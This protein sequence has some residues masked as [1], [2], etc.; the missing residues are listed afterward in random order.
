MQSGTAPRIGKFIRT[1]REKCCRTSEGNFFPRLADQDFILY[2]L[3]SCQDFEKAAGG[4]AAVKILRLGA[5][6]RSV[7]T[8]SGQPSD[9]HRLCVRARACVFLFF[10]EDKPCLPASL[11]EK[12]RKKR[13]RL[14]V[15]L[16]VL[17]GLTPPLLYL[18]VV[19]L[20]GKRETSLS[21]MLAAMLSVLR[22]I[23]GR[24]CKATT[25]E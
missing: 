25:G 16:I 14:G 2:R 4:T 23:S 13:N 10:I 18:F 8:L 17:A 3:D 15:R 1:G 5:E 9:P 19:R 11:E 7:G 12:K 20:E 22:P 24:G 21:L 6:S